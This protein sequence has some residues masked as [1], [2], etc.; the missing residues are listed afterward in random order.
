[1]RGHLHLLCGLD[2]RGES[3]LRRQSFRA[4]MHI[5]KS[6]TEAGTLVVNVV[7]PTAGILEGD[8]IEVEV[9]VETGARLLLTSPSASRS[10]RSVGRWS[11]TRQALRI[12]GRPT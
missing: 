9:A 3:S 10:H 5:S 7:N 11:E 8:F 2:D 6:F 12:A 4:P 1:M